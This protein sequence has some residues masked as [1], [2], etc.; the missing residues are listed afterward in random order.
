MKQSDFGK[1]RI[2]AYSLTTCANTPA[3][4]RACRCRYAHPSGIYTGTPTHKRICH[5]DCAR[6]Q[7]PR[8]RIR[9]PSPTQQPPHFKKPKHSEKFSISALTD[10]T[11]MISR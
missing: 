1:I 3:R 11:Y 5:A 4:R 7:S 9:G 10:L 2:D 8:A 6:H